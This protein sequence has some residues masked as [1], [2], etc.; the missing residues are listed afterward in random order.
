MV[1]FY[2]SVDDRLLKF[3]VILARH[4]GKYVFC[5]HKNRTTLEIPGGHREVNEDI[6]DTAK[7]EL[8]EETGAKDFSIKRV[9]VYSV[10]HKDNFD[11]QETFGM[12]YCADIKTFGNLEYEIEDVVITEDL[13]EK[14]TYPEIQPHLLNEIIR[15][16]AF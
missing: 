9:C 13:P 4:N 7:R 12:L 15:R 3:A 8:M 6:D 5:K 14:W 10:I 1:N 16:K 2:D 11:G